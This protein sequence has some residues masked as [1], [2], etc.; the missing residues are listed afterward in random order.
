M[1]PLQSKQLHR[2]VQTMSKYSPEPGEEETY[3]GAM[4]LGLLLLF[5]LFWCA[6]AWVVLG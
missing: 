2:R 5:V 3:I 4:A 1:P 6:I